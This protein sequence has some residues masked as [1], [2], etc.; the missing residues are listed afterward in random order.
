MPFVRVGSV[1][2]RD[3]D[4]LVIEGANRGTPAEGRQDGR[5]P[6]IELDA[7]R[8]R[9]VVSPWPTI[10][11]PAGISDARFPQA[12]QDVGRGLQEWGYGLKRACSDSASPHLRVA[13]DESEGEP[14]W[15][16]RSRV[17]ADEACDLFLRPHRGDAVASTATARR[18]A[19]RV[20]GDDLASVKEQ[21]GGLEKGREESA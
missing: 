2:T 21:I 19:L 12:R 13:V 3:L 8:H 20:D 16:D 11:V 14:A 17:S 10:Q 9:L 5:A 4:R 6:L 15:R 18:C 1:E 7:S